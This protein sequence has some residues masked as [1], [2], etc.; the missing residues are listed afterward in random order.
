[1][2]AWVPSRL[3]V[4]NRLLLAFLGISGLS[5]VGAA[6]AIFSF[7]DIGHALDRITAKRV[8]AALASVEVSR[9]AER[10][11][12]VA[13]ALLSAAT[14]AEHT[15]VSQRIGAEM[16]E[17]AGLLE[18]FEH[19]GADGVVLGPMRSVVGRLRIN[20]ESLNKLVADRLV[21]SE[22]KRGHLSD[23][24]TA[25]NE[26]QNLLTPWLQIVEGQIAQSRR[27]FDDAKLGIDERIAAG[28]GLVGSTTSYH[29]LQRVQFLITST[30]ERLQQI[31]ATDD[32][33][34]LRVHVFRIQRSLR[35]AREITASLD[36]R[37]Q[38]L[39]MVKLEEFRALVEGTNSI[40]EL[41]SQELG[42]VAQATRNLT[43]NAALSRE[44][45][46]AADRLVS[47]A[48]RDIAQA[49]DEALAA[50]HF[51]ST[52]LI[53]AVA[54]SL[55]S[56]IV[57]VWL[58]VGRNIV[59]RLT[60]LSRSMLAIAEG[61][62]A[63]KVP[64]GGSDEIAEMGAVVEILRKNTVERNELLL[65]REQTA[66]RLEKQVEERTIELARSIEELRALGEVSQA[67][68]STIDLQ[69]V[70]STIISKAVQLSGT[71][72]GT[73]YAFDD[74]RQEFKLRASY[75]MDEELV[76][77]IK[78]RNVQMGETMIS[79]AAIQRC[80]VQVADITHES[81]SL[82]LDVI[83]RAGFRALLAVPLLGADRIVGALVVRRKEPGK[84]PSGTVNLLQTFAEQS[85]LAIQNARMFQEIEE[86]GRE[87]AEAS[88]HK[89]QFLANMSHEIRTP[90]NAV[91]GMSSLLLDTELNEEQRDHASTIR[92]SSETLLTIINDILDFSKIEA[93]RMDI[94]AQPF[95]L[96]DCVESALDLVSS[97]AA[98]KR[99]DIAYLFEGEVPPAIQGDVTRLRQ[100]LLNLLS[101]AVKFTEQ[102]EVVLTVTTK[103]EQLEF[104][105]RDTGIGL[106]AKA[107]ARL[108]QSFSQADSST[109]R[110]YGGTGLGLAISKRLAELMG[111]TM[112][113]E[114]A[115]PGH[116]STFHFTISF[117]RTDLPK[118]TRRDFVGAQPALQ[119]KRILVVDDNATNR[120]ILALQAAKWGMAVHDTEAPEQA[121][122]V[123]MRDSFDLAILDM[124]MPGM[125]GATLAARIREAGHSLPLV[126]FS[127]AGSGKEAGDS[128]FAA[129]LAK[130]LRQSQ[131]FDTLVTLL[132]HEGA[133]RHVAA[134][135]RPRIDPQLASRHALR[136][137]LA[138]DNAVNQ[139]LALRLLQQ[140]GYRADL[141]SN[142]L[143]A[144]EC[145]A[146]QTYDVVLMDVQMP[147]MDGFEASRQITT[148][149]PA[150]QRPRI[151][152][153]T[154]NAMQGDRE[155]CLAAGMDD[156]VSKPIRVDELVAALM[157]VPT[158]RQ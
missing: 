133:R 67:V 65:E 150:G 155:L 12:S 24:L 76:A 131:F 120:R 143:E 61:N 51:T 136:I 158:R 7:R 54:L 91:I 31:S 95:D 55:L 106:D 43:E 79:Q 104:A 77:T 58:Y 22:L 115:G 17:L 2:R 53:A 57:I 124:H 52:V 68:N 13:P 123:L 60:S 37:L 117:Q 128:L 100:I 112:W 46:Q 121:L 72:A 84:F 36:S 135:A 138:E 34:S 40:P 105:V 140:M 94:E 113:V 29:A 87:L 69:T 88:Q 119:G 32:L 97:R 30:S 59:S 1:M 16:Q 23:A 21:V 3:G 122:E 49:N 101:N 118:G 18:G 14:P 80:P 35:E 71:D 109:T 45:T 151:I 89:S 85:V 107:Q 81:P 96:R 25:D 111:G 6:V 139:K 126:L 129:R 142:G 66:E 116:G 73:I 70:L 8:P 114:G 127:S 141:A 93:G 153:M 41:R 152:A 86:K 10:I 64:T 15:D 156:Y 98:E 145:V 82:V 9:R 125:D 132:A 108:F 38:P 47:I 147:G 78:E 27:A 56:S 103:G 63:A 149:W 144:I 110:K 20:L 19:R 50:Q 137:L 11:V 75:G 130:P 33:D 99:L 26:S 39:L 42:I 134:P 5:I 48:N 90:M 154:A 148:R 62:L 28:V 44:L 83:I 102:G 92:D 4:A 74:A 157:S 146:R